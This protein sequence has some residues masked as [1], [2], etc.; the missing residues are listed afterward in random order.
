MWPGDTPLG[1]PPSRPPI[2]IGVPKSSA[3]NASV[4]DAREQY[5]RF[6]ASLIRKSFSHDART[7]A[8]LLEIANFVA[9]FPERSGAV[10]VR[11]H[12]ERCKTCE[13]SQDPGRAIV[14]L[15]RPPPCRMPVLKI[16]HLAD[17]NI[18]MGQS[19]ARQTTNAEDELK[20][21]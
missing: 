13:G 8:K 18:E 7:V 10:L 1:R 9:F 20:V 15:V 6:V 12:A 2:E 19:K 11:P 5:S 17:G 21:L 16:W 3:W 4:H 14:Q